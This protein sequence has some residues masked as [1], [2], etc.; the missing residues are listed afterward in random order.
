MRA[1]TDR[2]VIVPQVALDDICTLAER[3]DLEA[4]LATLERLAPRILPITQDVGLAIHNA[5]KNGASILLEGAQGSMLD[6]DHGT[7]PF[8]TSSSTTSGGAA[9]GVGIAPS[10][11]HAR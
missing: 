1:M 10:S 2:L 4:T 6:V 3:A 8:V 5:I 9:I 11:I 7:Y